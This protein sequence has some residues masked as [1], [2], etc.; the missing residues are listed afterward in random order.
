MASEQVTVVV[1]LRAKPGRE[2][3]VQQELHALLAPTRAERGCIN[4][5]MHTA[6]NDPSLF[7]FYENWESE[8]LLQAHL[9]NPQLKRWIA[10]AEDLLAEPM[11]LS[12]WRKAD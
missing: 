11:Q 4:Y 3:Q 5:D 8:A 1:R 7:L 10:L 6:P 2:A 9:Q 12:L